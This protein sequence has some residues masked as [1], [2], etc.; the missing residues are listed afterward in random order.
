MINFKTKK[1]INSKKSPIN[2]VKHRF[3]RY[4]KLKN[5]QYHYLVF[6]L[7][8]LD[9][10]KKWLRSMEVPEVGILGHYCR[11]IIKIIRLNN[12]L[13]TFYKQIEII[14]SFLKNQ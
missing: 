4:V 12:N 7:N 6:K 13:I 5:I 10:K 1:A 3:A 9:L 14:V 11:L 2:F 8:G